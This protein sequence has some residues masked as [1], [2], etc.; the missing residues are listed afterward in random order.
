MIMIDWGAFPRVELGTF[1]TPL[2]ELKNAGAALGGGRRLF[3]KRDDLTGIVLGGNKVRKLEFLLADAVA[4]GCDTIITAG[5]AQSNHAAI[6]AACCN[7]LGLKSILVLLKRGETGQKGNLL[8]NRIQ[9]ADVRFVDSDSMGDIYPAMDAVAGEVSA[10]GG[11]PY[12]VPVGGST[13]LGALGY[14][15][16]MEELFAQAKAQKLRF[17]HIVCCAGSGGTFAG[18]VLGTALYSPAT[19]VTGISISKD[20]SGQAS[21]YKLIRET[22]DLIRADV[23]L[24]EDDVVLKQYCGKGYAVPSAEGNDAIGKMAAWEGLFLDPVY[25]G[26][27]FA[28]L[29]DLNDKRYFPEKSSILFMHTGGAATLFAIAME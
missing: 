26:K 10:A 14:V 24:K 8:L 1:P 6:T 11:K 9:G 20:L 5:G 12:I 13:P 17:D 27:T 28:G 16:G 21:I 4:K 3:V 23:G 25:T 19:R 7:R 2:R 29:L 22:A 15:L 18:V